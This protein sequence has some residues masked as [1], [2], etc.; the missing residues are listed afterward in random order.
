MLFLFI[1][2]SPGGLFPEDDSWFGGRKF[3]LD[4]RRDL[5]GL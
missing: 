4:L 5:V 2:L 3:D 1:L